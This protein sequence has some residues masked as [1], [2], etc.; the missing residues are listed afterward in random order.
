MTK[1]QKQD[2]IERQRPLGRKISECDWHGCNKNGLFLVKMSMDSDIVQRF[3]STHARLIAN[4]SIRSSSI[5][6]QD[7]ARWFENSKE[8]YSTRQD[9][10]KTNTYYDP[11]FNDVIRTRKIRPSTKYQF[12]RDDIANLIVLGL[13]SRAKQ[14]DIKNAYKKLVKEYH[15][16]QNPDIKNATET[17]SK[18]NNAYS[19]L[20]NKKIE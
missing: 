18:I 3:C 14:V 13:D 20:K 15:P 19:A 7:H 2:N 8:N 12:T 16:D 6:Q 1:E 5:D 11:A 9:R 4:S 17:L 10:R